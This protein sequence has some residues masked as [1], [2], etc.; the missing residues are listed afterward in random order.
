MSQ[1]RPIRR[2]G[3][4]KKVIVPR[5]GFLLTLTAFLL[6][7]P[8]PAHAYVDP[9]SGSMLWQIAAAGVIGSL[10]YVRR[11]FT[12]VRERVGFL[13]TSRQAGTKDSP[14]SNPDCF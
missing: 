13:T 11:M 10:F 7:T 12:W 6:A 5:S 14:T 1:Q 4:V 8:K 2:V 9:G 3:L